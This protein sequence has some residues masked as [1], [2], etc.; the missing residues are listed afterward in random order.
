MLILP[1]IDL[2]AGRCVRL[3]QGDFQQE[4]VF[5]DDPVAVARQW[6]AQGATNLHLV[7][8][9]GAREGRPVNGPA[10]QRIVSAC[11]V[12]CQL[13]GGLR[14]NEDVATALSWGV[15][16]VVLGTRAIGDL[17]WLSGLCD[18]YPGRVAVGIDAKQGNPAS[19]GW[20]ETTNR[21]A[22][23]VARECAGLPIAA[24]IYTDISRDGM[25]AGPDFDAYSDLVGAVQVPVI[26][27]GGITT[28]EDVRQL[29]RIGLAGC[30]IGRALYEGR[31]QLTEA[32]R[33][34]SNI[35]RR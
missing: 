33:I 15:A 6:I 16:R 35:S 18:H 26:A 1:A 22:N 2:R 20:T 14:S 30:I 7:D 17:N 10:I 8:L 21:S 31:I 32:I 19:H 12:P 34:A 5:N 11:G 24:L 27:S 3:R 9:D 25:L 29:G 4:T 28:E 13:G 23:E